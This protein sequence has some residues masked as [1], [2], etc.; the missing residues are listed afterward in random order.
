MPTDF[1][2][3]LGGQTFLGYMAGLPR[4]ERGP[5]VLVIPG[6][7]G[8]GPQAK[9]RAEMLA[10]LGYV[11]FAADL[12]GEPIRGVEHAITLVRHFTE[13]WA[14]LRA[15]C[16]G[17]LDVLL[18]QSNVDPHRTAAVGYCFG[19]Q[20]ALELGRSGIDLRCIVGFHSQLAT[21]RSEDS[22]NIR[23][24]VLVCLGDQDCF[25]SGTDRDQFMSD[26]TAS[27]VDC[28]LLLFS[29]I[30]HSFTDPHAEASGLPG[31][32]F[33]A[34]ADRRAWAAMQSLFAEAF[35]Q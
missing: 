27:K 25:V 13:H 33:D 17:A 18:N 7:G 34:K 23:A 12:F 22:K 3:T 31:L 29:G 4:K 14:E 15:R 35:A 5:G 16:K 2:Y 6:A 28:Q 32:K 8:L 9:K 19:G 26:M 1:S 11:A 24:K 30:G 21:R 20:A 10:D